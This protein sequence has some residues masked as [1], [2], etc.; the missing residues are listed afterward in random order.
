MKIPGV[1]M[2]SMGNRARRALQGLAAG[3]ALLLASC[4]GGTEQVTPFDPTRY[5]IFGDEMSYLTADGRK[6]TVN[7]LDG[8]GV[9]DCSIN[10]SSEPSRI[11][12]Q[13]L[14]SAFGFRLA[15]CNPND[16]TVNAFIFAAPGAKVEDFVGQVAA[17]RLLHGPFGCHDLMSVLLG[18]NDVID[19]FENVYLASP[20]QATADQVTNELSARAARLGRAIAD[21]TADN[22]P[23]FIVSTMPLMNLTPYARQMASVHPNANVSNVLNQMST[24]F[25]T[26][27]RTNIPNDGTRWGLV[28][29]DALLNAG[30]NNPGTYGLN[31]V[32]DAVCDPA[33]WGTAACTTNTLV[34][35]GNADTWLWASNLWMGWKAHQNLGN[36]ARNRADGNP[37]GCG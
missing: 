19:L 9:P 28:E 29:L 32:R 33:T 21:L 12:V 7:A 30:F 27:L 11:W 31:N 14:A 18:A 35:N 22:G 17:A 2:N 37:F 10:T 13:V 3:L 23:N 34:A 36:F 1:K 16:R 24:A 25:N 5:M 8:N 20:S 15:E 26:A 4:G 6:Y